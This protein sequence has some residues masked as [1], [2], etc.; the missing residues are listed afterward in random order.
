VLFVTLCKALALRARLVTTLEPTAGRSGG[1]G[2]GAKSEPRPTT[3]TGTVTGVPGGRH[4]G[5]GRI[6]VGDLSRRISSRNQ[7]DP[8]VQHRRQQE[9][10]PVQTGEAPPPAAPSAQAWAEVYCPPLSRWVALCPVSAICDNP[11]AI[12][13]Y[14]TKKAKSPPGYIVAVGTNPMLRITDVSRRYI[15]T[16]YS[17][18]GG[19]KRVN[20]KWWVDTVSQMSARP[21][22]ENT[23]LETSEQEELQ[24]IAARNDRDAPIP[25]T[26]AACKRHPLYVMEEHLTKSQCIK[27]DA[28]HVGF[29]NGAKVYL[30]SDISLLLTERKWLTAHARVIKPDAK[31]HSYQTARPG[32]GS[33]GSGA[34]SN[35]GDATAAAA[36]A[37][38]QQQQQQQS[39]STGINGSTGATR[40]D[41]SGHAQGA[42]FGV[43]QTVPFVP[44]VATGGIVPRNDHGNVE[45]WNCNPAFVPGGCSHVDEP[46]I[47]Q[48][49][50]E[51]KI[52]FA[53]ALVGFKHTATG[54]T[55]KI[56]G[57]FVCTESLDRLLKAH[58]VKMEA[59]QEA[60]QRKRDDKLAQRWRELITLVVSLD[61]VSREYQ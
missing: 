35:D 24:K 50:N 27:P 22:S 36:A 11:T 53:E 46:W 56:E 9:F 20:E 51:L 59:R 47:Q 44:P 3:A 54:M 4:G 2:S 40:A 23:A 60:V 18:L 52:N 28:K 21:D 39:S 48:T 5:K 29:L 34:R 12:L 37:Q 30:A 25:K 7:R 15:K 10:V 57:I 31:P 32:F 19:P 14:W 58:R 8:R 41:S 16:W 38:Q 1:G 61:R 45:F 49:C 6:A 43:W 55:P 17:V 42:L 33:M 13:E 26:K